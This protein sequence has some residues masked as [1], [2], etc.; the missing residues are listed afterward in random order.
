MESV[1]TM[2]GWMTGKPFTVKCKPGYTA[3]PEKGNLICVDGQWKN[4]SNCLGEFFFLLNIRNTC[5]LNLFLFLNIAHKLPKNAQGL[6]NMS[7]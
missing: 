5:T 2:D 6:I 3:K 1:S 7:L 4:P